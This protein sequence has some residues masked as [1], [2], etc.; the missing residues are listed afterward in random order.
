MTG[1]D[2]RGPGQNRENFCRW[3]DWRTGLPSWISRIG[4]RI[5]YNPGLVVIERL[6]EE[7]KAGRPAIDS[8]KHLEATESARAKGILADWQKL[9]AAFGNET[10]SSSRKACGTPRSPAP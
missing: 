1:R 3:H 8:I 4:L 10:K 6:T 5:S 2:A 7:D 9:P